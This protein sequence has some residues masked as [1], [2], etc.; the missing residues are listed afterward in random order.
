[1]VTQNTKNDVIIRNHSGIPVVE[2]VGELNRAAIGAIESSISALASAGHY[3]IVLNIRKAVAA[4]TKALESLKSSAEA[5]V[6]HYGAIDIVGEAGQIG[7]LLSLDGL[8]KA[9]RFCTSE[10]EALRK[11]KKLTRRPEDNEQGCSAHVMETK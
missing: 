3:H 4:N 9:F 5:V 10:N 7:Q 2:I 8:A 1:M 11:I 6:K